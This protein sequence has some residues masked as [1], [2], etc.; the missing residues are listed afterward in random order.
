MELVV[1]NLS[2][3]ARDVRDTCL[4]PGSGGSHGGRHGSPVQYSCLEN[5]KDRGAWGANRV[6]ELDTTE[7]TQHALTRISTYTEKNQPANAGDTG[8]IPGPRRSHMPQSN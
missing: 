6:A 7:A 8:S 2:A 3:N 5:P 1:K 4:I